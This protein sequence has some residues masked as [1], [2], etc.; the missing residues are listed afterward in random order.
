MFK[1]AIRPKTSRAV[2]SLPGGCGHESLVETANASLAGDD[3]N[4][5]E[6]A[7]HS[8]DGVLAVVDSAFVSLN[9]GKA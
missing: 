2:G 9:V 7:T 5:M 4:G 6:K 8:G 3:G 1:E